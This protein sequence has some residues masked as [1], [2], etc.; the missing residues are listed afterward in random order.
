MSKARTGNKELAIWKTLDKKQKK[1]LSIMYGRVNDIEAVRQVQRKE[2]GKNTYN[3]K[4]VVQYDLNNGR[5][6]YI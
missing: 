5:Y 2:Q 1:K 4:K 3:A 6:S